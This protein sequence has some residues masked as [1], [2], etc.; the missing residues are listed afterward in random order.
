MPT[1]PATAPATPWTELA[2]P[3]CL[4]AAD[5]V[6]GL[7]HTGGKVSHQSQHVGRG[8]THA[9]LELALLDEVDVEVAGVEAAE[10]DEEEEGEE[11]EEE[12]VE[13][14]PLLLP[15]MTAAVP[16]DCPLAPVESTTSNC[17]FFPTSDESGEKM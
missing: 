7:R 3:V 14:L 13:A 9:E 12:P 15:A 5:E 10:V 8:E 4:G 16:P 2:A 1:T 6:V 11:A 17:R